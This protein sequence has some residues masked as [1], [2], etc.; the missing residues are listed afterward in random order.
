MNAF[1]E[2]RTSPSP[3][4]KMIW[5]GAA[6]DYYTPACPADGQWNL[7]FLKRDGKVRVS[8]EGPL[9][10]V[11]H[12]VHAEGTEWLVIKFQPGA[13]LPSLPV[14]N[15]VDSDAVLPLTTAHTFWLHGSAWPFPS[16][17]NVET[18]ID[19]L[20]RKD[21]LRFD[22]VVKAAV[23][24]QLLESSSRTIRRHFLLT[25]GLTQ[26]ALAQIERAQ[27]AA[28]LLEQG[29]PLLD[30]AYQAGYADQSHMSRSLKRFL[31]QTPTQIVNIRKAP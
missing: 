3:Y 9:T 14:Q 18:F 6:L 25:T 22:P 16:Y 27:K 20:V 5:R 29:I 7:L 30:V 1:F 12:K 13:F 26:R 10:Q 31:G 28:A 4:I 19:K 11:K 8:I 24:N 2:G 15:L 23:Q 21:E 17:E